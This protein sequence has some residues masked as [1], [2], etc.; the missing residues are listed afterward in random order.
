MKINLKLVSIALVFLAS[1][2]LVCAENIS[3]IYLKK[4]QHSKEVVNETSVPKKILTPLPNTEEET[5]SKSQNNFINNV[6]LTSNFTNEYFTLK[7]IDKSTT[8]SSTLVS[9]NSNKFRINLAFESETLNYGLFYEYHPFEIYQNNQTSNWTI[10]NRKNTARS[11]GA[12]FNLKLNDH[13]K[14]NICAGVDDSFFVRTINNSNL[15]I[16]MLYSE[17]LALSYSHIFQVKD[18]L[19]LIPELKLTNHFATS[20]DSFSVKNGESAMISLGIENQFE[21]THWILKSFYGEKYQES[22]YSKDRIRTLGI[23]L[24]LQINF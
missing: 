19:N 20:K 15:S 7:T 2:G 10:N 16:D 11:M 18:H 21:K 3:E 8:A 14:I 23:G 6:K 5:K 9:K 4:I 1:T 12:D 17:F 24:G 22:V 13:N